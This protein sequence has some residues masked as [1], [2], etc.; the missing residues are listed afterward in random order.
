[1]NI[2]IDEKLKRVVIIGAGF[3]GLQVAKKLKR[4]KFQVI[5][6]DKN[7]YHT[8]QPLLYQVATSGLE[9]DSIAHSIRTIIKQTHNFFFRLAH[10]HDINIK[11]N[12]IYT[13]VGYIKYDYLIIAVGSVTNYF[14]N[15]NIENFSLPMKSIPEALNLRSTI[16]QNFEYA[17]LTNNK[18]EKERLMNFVIVGGGPTGVEL[19]GALAEMKK[20]VLPYDYPDLDIQKMNI[21]LLQAS[22]RLLDGMSTHSAK[23]AFNNLKDLGVNIWINCLVKDYDGKVVFTATGHN[24]ESFNVIWAAGVKGA[25]IKGFFKEDI[26]SKVDRILVN[27]YLR[28]LKY[29]NIFAIGDIAY[30]V[31]N[32]Y[33]PNG[34]PMTAAPAIQQGNYLANYFNNCLLEKDKINIKPFIYKHFG[35]MATIGRNKAVCDFNSL[36]LKG[37]LAWIVWMSVHLFSLVGFRNRVIALMNWIIQYFQYHKS[38]RLIIRPFN[39][40]K[41]KN[42]K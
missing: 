9:P 7:N 29:D 35:S 2:P 19:A 42:N 27:N 3:A 12:K 34:H 8:F 36:K 16:L 1:M 41:E 22:P 37:F 17:L 31:S 10:V 21:H 40:K 33:Y 32:K 20:Y 24:I 18:K 5:L 6:I 25:M 30:M 28:T 13:N 38:V 23:Q 11:E 26:N 4:H 39:R 15:K 14:G